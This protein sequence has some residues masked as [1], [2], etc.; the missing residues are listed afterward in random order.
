MPMS[1][2]YGRSGCCTDEKA[3]PD[4]AGPALTC[5]QA[6]CLLFLVCEV[7]AVGLVPVAAGEVGHFYG[8]VAV[9]HGDCS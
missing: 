8:H 4:S 9:E 7:E 3:G 6:G 1:F 5:V 2:R